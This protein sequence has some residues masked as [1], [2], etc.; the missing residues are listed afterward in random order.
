[1]HGHLNVKITLLLDAL[2]GI[3]REGK[4]TV[5]WLSVQLPVSHDEVKG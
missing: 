4:V 5:P 1:M 3:V 2:I